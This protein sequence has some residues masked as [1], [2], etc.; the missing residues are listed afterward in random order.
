MDF[1]FAEHFGISLESSRNNERFGIKIKW[2]RTTEVATLPS[3]FVTFNVAR[4]DQVACTV[5]SVRR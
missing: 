3:T 4:A 5:F 2:V 1:F